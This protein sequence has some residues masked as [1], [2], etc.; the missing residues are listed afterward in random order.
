M[1]KVRIPLI[2]LTNR[3]ALLCSFLLTWIIAAAG[4]SNTHHLLCDVIFR[5][6]FGQGQGVYAEVVRIS[7]LYHKPM[8]GVVQCPFLE[9]KDL[10]MCPIA[11][12]A[13]TIGLGMWVEHHRSWYRDVLCRRK[14]PCG[15]DCLKDFS[16]FQLSPYHIRR[17]WIRQ[18]QR[19]LEHLLISLLRNEGAGCKQWVF[20][21]KWGGYATNTVVIQSGVCFDARCDL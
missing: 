10:W 9:E 12:H 15:C 7:P 5:E 14:C 16:Q 17:V 8:Y 4:V 20:P 21:P 1:I 19:S 3:R 11:R 2:A 18:R 6:G 13:R